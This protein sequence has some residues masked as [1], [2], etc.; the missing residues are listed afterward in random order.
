MGLRKRFRPRAASSNRSGD[1]SDAN[2][3]RN[4]NGGVVTCRCACVG[5]LAQVFR[6][7]AADRF[8]LRFPLSENASKEIHKVVCLNKHGSAPRSGEYPL[9]FRHRPGWSGSHTGRKPLNFHCGNCASSAAVPETQ[10]AFTGRLFSTNVESNRTPCFKRRSQ[11]CAEDCD[12]L[13]TSMPLR[14]RRL[15]WRRCRVFFPLCH[16]KSL[17]G[18]SGMS[19]GN[20]YKIEKESLRIVL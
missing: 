15:R 17:N 18:R 8:R 5:R 3:R 20:L 13:V 11:D 16:S 10:S 12:W 7:C 1:S 4:Q 14:R 6:T 9:K 19:R 2:K